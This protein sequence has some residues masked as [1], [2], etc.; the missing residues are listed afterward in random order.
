MEPATQEFRAV[1]LMR[2][3]HRELIK[4]VELTKAATRTGSLDQLREALRIL[5]RACRGHMRTEDEKVFPL[6]EQLAPADDR[7]RT[8]QLAM[9]HTLIERSLNA[10]AW[11]LE[12]EESFERLDEHVRHFAALLEVHLNDEELELNRMCV[13]LLDEGRTTEVSLLL[14]EPW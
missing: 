11:E 12:S 14:A 4:L 13:H 6:F 2:A 10:L 7:G 8:Q 1:Q 9:Q 5:E 3:K